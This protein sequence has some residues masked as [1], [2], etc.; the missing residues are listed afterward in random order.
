[1]S[2]DSLDSEWAKKAKQYAEEKSHLMLWG[3]LPVPSMSDE[4]LN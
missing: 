1:M 2:N 3:T 4:I